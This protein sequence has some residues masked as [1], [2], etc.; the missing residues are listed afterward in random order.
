MK[1][2]LLL[3]LLSASLTVAGSIEVSDAYFKV[4]PPT[5]KNSAAFMK[6]KNTSGE[7]VALIGGSSDISEFTEIHTHL[8]EEGMMKMI[9]VK[10]LVVP[11]KGEVE[12]KP[13]EF[14]VMLIGLKN[15]V[16]VGDKMNL[17]L[18]FDNDE[19]VELKNLV[20][21]EVK[22]MHHMAH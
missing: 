11:A 7:D 4:T 3:S 17:K 13:G 9:K 6:I 12:L 1:K 19:V 21:K 20:A 14:H 16:K 22:P 18:K 5:G 15:P 8:K 2:F 10:K